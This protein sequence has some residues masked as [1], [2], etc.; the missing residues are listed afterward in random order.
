VDYTY[1]RQEQLLWERLG[2]IDPRRL[3]RLRVFAWVQRLAIPAV[4]VPLASGLY[5]QWAPVACGAAAVTGTV[6][7]LIERPAARRM[8]W[9][10]VGGGRRSVR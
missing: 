8:V 6:L 4:A 5:V 9:P 2:Q 3:R 1:W 7:Y 10:E